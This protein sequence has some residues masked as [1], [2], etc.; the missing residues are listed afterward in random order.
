MSNDYK[1]LII[2]R[3]NDFYKN[4]T[5]FISQF[6]DISNYDV[7][8]HNF[9]KEE[10]DESVFNKIVN[11][12]VSDSNSS[13]SDTIKFFYNDNLNNYCLVFDSCIKYNDKIII[14]TLLC[15]KDIFIKIEGDKCNTFFI[16]GKKIQCDNINIIFDYDYDYSNKKNILL[17]GT[18]NSKFLY[19]L[20]NNSTLYIYILKYILDIDIDLDKL[21]TPLLKDNEKYYNILLKVLI[22]GHHSDNIKLILEL[23]N[24]KYFNQDALFILLRCIKDCS[25]LDKKVYEL[26]IDKIPHEF[27]NVTNFSSLIDLNIMYDNKECVDFVIK[28]NMDKIFTDIY[29][30]PKWIYTDQNKLIVPYYP[31]LTD[32]DIIEMS[33]P[34]KINKNITLLSNHIYGL[35][36]NILNIKEDKIIYNECEIP[37][38]NKNGVLVLYSEEGLYLYTQA[39]PILI[40]TITDNNKLEIV[41]DGIFNYPFINYKLIGNIVTYMN[42]YIG[43]IRVENGSYRLLILDTHMLDCI[44]I[45]HNFNITEGVVIGLYVENNNIY[46]LGELIEQSETKLYKQI[47]CSEILFFELTNIFNLKSCIDLQI[48]DKNNIFLDIPEWEYETYT[49]DNFVFSR[50]SNYDIKASY[51]P[52]SKLLTIDDKIKYKKEFIYF[53]N[54]TLELLDKTCELYFHESAKN[55]KLYEKS[56]ALNISIS[57]NYS[58]AKYLVIDQTEFELLTSLELSDIINNNTLIISLIDNELLNNNI[59]VNNYTGTP[60]LTKLFLFNIVKNITYVNFIFDKIIHKQEYSD[61]KNFI[62]VD[63]EHIFKEASIYKNILDLYKSSDIIHIELSDKEEILCNIVKSKILNKIAPEIYKNILNIC[64]FIIERNFNIRILLQEIDVQ[65]NNKLVNILNR[66]NW[67]GNIDTKTDDSGPLKN[68]K[69]DII[70]INTQEEL[71]DI[72]LK[73]EGLIYILESNILLKL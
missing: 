1:I 34:Y 68:I 20:D 44:E 54:N 62:N 12:N 13:I 17:S 27:E 66:L 39:N 28:Y 50:G 2:Y 26:I 61:R 25:N 10:L 57:E 56:Q 60:L 29:S 42:M 48:N 33:Y 69:Y 53:P 31:I 71:L 63:K 32:K 8:L 35:D 11:Y 18:I 40:Y 64:K 7:S 14:D 45:S 22:K 43:I 19:N 73:N 23:F 5:D 41:E 36:D 47:I 65:Y 59:L 55:T 70:I 49:Y 3:P 24:S 72:K 9:T 58:D 46:I 38:D 16:L 37:F 67:L 6:T 52:K 21:K 30:I 4:I 51:N 15:D